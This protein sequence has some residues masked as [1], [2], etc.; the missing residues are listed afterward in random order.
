MNKVQSGSDF[1]VKASTWNSF[2]D[3][4]NANKNSQ[5]NQNFSSIRNSL[6]SGE[7][8]IKN[9]TSTTMS[10]FSTLTLGEVLVKP[11]DNESEF[12][13]RL[14]AFTGYLDSDSSRPF[15]ILLEPIEVGK[16]GKGLIMGVT[17]AL[18]DII[19]SDHQYAEPTET[20]TL[21]SC[22]SGIARILWQAN[23][24]G[25]QWCVLQLGG[26]GSAA[27]SISDVV[28]CKIISAISST[29]AYEVELYKNGPDEDSTGTGT[30]FLTEISIS[31]QLPAGTWV[32]GHP[33]LIDEVGGND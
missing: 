6:K 1:E 14:P 32:L 5:N 10:Q 23:E 3:A 21:Q 29:G 12:K 20:G 31:S 9:M 27:E 18:V 22:D 4:A 30:L 25:S 17:P 15:A 11:S 26:G 13:N 28:M 19:S 8:F 16:I 7:I 2:I 33:I 24:S